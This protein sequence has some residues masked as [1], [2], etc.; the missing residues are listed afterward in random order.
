MTEIDVRTRM[1][2]SV[3]TEEETRF[4]F[5]VETFPEK[6]WV[7]GFLRGGQKETET[8]KRSILNGGK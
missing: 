4:G 2:R 6:D 8:H 7:R 1:S 3:P 5:T